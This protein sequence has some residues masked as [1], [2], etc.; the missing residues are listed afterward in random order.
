MRRQKCEPKLAC[1]GVSEQRGICRNALTWNEL[2]V[3]SARWRG[4][5]GPSQNENGLSNLV[6][7]AG[8]N[9]VGVSRPPILRVNG[10]L[11]SAGLEELQSRTG[12]IK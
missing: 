10:R 12:E 7:G 8:F 6:P 2:V 4:S 1:P 11:P 3:V 9:G 5:V